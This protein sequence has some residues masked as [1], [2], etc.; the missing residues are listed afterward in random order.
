METPQEFS[1]RCHRLLSEAKDKSLHLGND[2]SALN[3][4][5][6]VAKQD[7][8]TWVNGL[9]FAIEKMDGN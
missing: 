7:G 5:M 2:S 6:A 3:R 8:K 1:A 4:W 9:A